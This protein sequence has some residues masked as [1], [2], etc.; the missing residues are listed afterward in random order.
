MPTIRTVT[1]QAAGTTTPN[2]LTGSQFEFLGVASRIQI[3]AI[4]DSTGAAGVGQV[5]VFFGQELQL[6][7]SQVNLKA[8]GPEI[9][10]DLVV[11]DFGAG[12]DRLV[13]RVVETGGALGATVNILVKITPQPIG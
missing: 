4:Q 10:E 8:A 1:V 2:V 13:V 6:S 7:Q 11:D 12:G 3:Y 5:E 9:P